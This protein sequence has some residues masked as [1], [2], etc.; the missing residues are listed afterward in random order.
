MSNEPIHH[1]EKLLAEVDQARAAGVFQTTRVSLRDVASVRG[2]DSAMSLLR[3]VRLP[4]GMAA[5]LG[6]V[7]VTGAL[8]TDQ[9]GR[10]SS[11]VVLPN[12]SNRTIQNSDSPPYVVCLT[13]PVGDGRR[14]GCLTN[15]VDGDGDVD[16]A[17]FSARQRAGG[18]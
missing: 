14:S 16:L 3:R 2:G 15:D 10:N 11:N 12:G 5:C 18:A 6:A 7:L 13:G 8:F 17:D 4:L 1:V 9:L